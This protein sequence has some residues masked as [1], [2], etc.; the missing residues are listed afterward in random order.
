MKIKVT[1]EKEGH[2]NPGHDMKRLV[3]QVG[4]HLRKQQTTDSCEVKN[5]GQEDPEVHEK[6]TG[7]GRDPE[8]R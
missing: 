3:L 2:D 8:S 4:N 5:R 6:T 1:G 7:G